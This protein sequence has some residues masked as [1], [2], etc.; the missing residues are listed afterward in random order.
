MWGGRPRLSGWACG[1][2]IVMKTRLE[3]GQSCPQPA[4][5]RLLAALQF[6]ITYG[7]LS[8]VR[9][10]SRPAGLWGRLTTCRPIVKRPFHRPLTPLGLRLA[11]V[12]GR[13]AACGPAQAAFF[14]FQYS[15][16]LVDR[17]APPPRRAIFAATVSAAAII[18][19]FAYPKSN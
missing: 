16:A 3:G 7:G 19:C 9:R 18:V 1:P 15:T 17:V 5:S 13:L 12:R 8:T 6:S 14:R 11:A 2:R 10:V 4:F